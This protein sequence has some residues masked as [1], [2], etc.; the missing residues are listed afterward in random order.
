[1]LLHLSRGRCRHF[2]ECEL[3]VERSSHACLEWDGSDPMLVASEGG[4]SQGRRHLA[5]EGPVKGAFTKSKTQ[6]SEMFPCRR[7]FNPVQPH[8]SKQELKTQNS[9]DVKKQIR[10]GE[11]TEN[12]V[13][14]SF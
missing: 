8:H 10:A 12:T 4:C 11:N 9:C 14:P 3:D 2:A 1:M 7:V 6:L 5:S 13:E